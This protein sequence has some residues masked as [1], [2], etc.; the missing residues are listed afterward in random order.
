MVA[1]IHL[2]KTRVERAARLYANNRDAGLSLGITPGAFG[3]A[4]RRFGIET[5]QQR[6]KKQERRYNGI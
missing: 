3:R 4:C 5:P 1:G 2:E 6:Q